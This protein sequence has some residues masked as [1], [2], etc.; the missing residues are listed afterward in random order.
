VPATS[1]NLAVGYDVMAMSLD[2]VNVFELSVSPNTSFEGFDPMYQNKYNL[3]YQSYLNTLKK[4]HKE[5]YQ[6]NVV[7]KKSHIPVSRG[8]GSS[9]SCVLA[10]VLGANSLHD[11]NLSRLEML[12]IASEIE[13]HADNA[14]AALYGGLVSVL[15]DHDH[16]DVFSHT[17]HE[18]LNL[19]VV[20]PPFRGSTRQLREVVPHKLSVQD[21]VFHI[22]RGLLVSKA[23]ALGDIDLLKTVLQDRIHQ[24]KRLEVYGLLELFDALN[25]LACITT[26]SGSGSSLLVIHKA[27]IDL[28]AIVPSE[29][30]VKAVSVNAS[31]MCEV[32]S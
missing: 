28:T 10:G 16:L 27:P 31:A 23:F 6:L 19:Q 22:E 18:S 15:H 9:A 3:V 29:Y 25:K 24:T 4:V 17:V 2:L 1:A 7:L 30:E 14:A 5:P 8:L 21:T 26:L 12:K 32:V 20:I 11:L 13:G